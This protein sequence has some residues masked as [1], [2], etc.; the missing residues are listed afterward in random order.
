MEAGVNIIFY[1]T[2]SGRSP[3]EEFIEALPEK[4]QAKISI[5]AT[6]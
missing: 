5:S 2:A 3:V 1:L 6:D 4:D